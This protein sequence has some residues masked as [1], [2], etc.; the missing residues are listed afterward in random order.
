MWPPSPIYVPTYATLGLQAQSRRVF[1]RSARR[2]GGGRLVQRHCDAPVLTVNRPDTANRRRHDLERSYD[3]IP[4]MFPVYAASPAVSPVALNYLGRSHFPAHIGPSARSLLTS[5][6][7]RRVL[8]PYLAKGGVGCLSLRSQPRRDI[9]TVPA[10]LGASEQRGRHR[11]QHNYFDRCYRSGAIC[12]RRRN[13]DRELQ[14]VGPASPW[15]ECDHPRSVRGRR[16]TTPPTRSGSRR[17]GRKSPCGR[18][19][20]RHQDGPCVPSATA[21]DGQSH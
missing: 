17:V 19:G 10:E 5:G 9:A 14:N 1:R 4:P 7:I 3:E 6:L 21:G 20:D 15:K 8:S 12:T 16:A 11:N 13:Q 2:G 18:S